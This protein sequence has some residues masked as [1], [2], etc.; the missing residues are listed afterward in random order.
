LKDIPVLGLLAGTQDNV[1]SRT[2]LLVL[3]TPHVVRDAR[4][5]KA[6]TEDL[7]EQ[8]HNA[9]LIPAEFTRLPPSGSAD[10]SRPLRQ[11]LNLD[12]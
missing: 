4:E 5:A 7:R 8:M 12:Q 2:E 6:L 1:R 10:P 3:I 9:A 11:K